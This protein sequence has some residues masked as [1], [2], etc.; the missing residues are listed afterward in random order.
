MA[1][2]RRRVRLLIAVLAL[3]FA[4]VVAR[5]LRP[6]VPVSPH[7]PS[8]RTDP[9]AVAEVT[10]GRLERIT[11]SRQDVSVDFQR[12]LL[13]PDGSMKLFAVKI[14]T[15]ERGGTRTFT[16]TG[17]EG[18]VGEKE[19]VLTLDGDVQ[20]VAS[21]GLTVRTEHATY[22]GRDGFVRAPGPVQFSRGRTKGSGLGMTYD[23]NRDVLDVLHD[24][25]LSIAPDSNGAGA[26]EITSAA[27]EFARR[28]RY[29]R[30]DN[31]V[32]IVRG[33][34][35][36][37]A[38]NATAYLTED[39]ERIDTLD[40]RDNARITV[41]GAAVGGLQSLAGG[42]MNLKYGSD[43][44]S[45]QHALIVG[46]AVVQIAGDAGKAG[47][48]I[49][50]GTL[51]IGLAPDGSTPIALAARENVQLT[52][53]AE[54]GTVGRTIQ[55]ANL[56]AKGVAERGL[57][58]AHF[59]GSVR[60]LEA[61]QG[62]SRAARSETLDAALKP[63]M[64]GLEDA[65]FVRGVHFEEGKLVATSATA[66]YQPD[67]GTLQLSG[68]EAGAV[69]PRVVNDQIAVDAAQID[70]TLDGPKVKATGSPADK[71]K[72]VLQPA[73][74]EDA[75]PGATPVKMPSMLK[76]D[77]PVNVTAATLDYDGTISKTAYSGSAQL[78]Q[79]DTSIKGETLVID[80]KAGDLSATAVTTTTLLEQ[81]NNETKKKERVRSTATAKDLKYEDAVRRMT[82]TGDA[83]M[84]GPEGD[85]TAATIELYLKPSGDELER[86]EAY[87]AVTL[88]EQHRKTTGTRMTYTT[89][90]ERYVIV[91][92]PVKIVDQCE[93]ETTGRTLT[94]LKASD[95]VVVDGNQETRTETKGGGKC[96]S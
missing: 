40:L 94:F 87:E 6:R 93:R 71:V 10:D 35:T 36:I 83:H 3:A 31:G 38:G 28:D 92:A 37:E 72:S 76:Q 88:R 58:S 80:G 78:W 43:G 54:A 13:Y 84:I 1:L 39:G 32:R 41:P 79:G 85:M 91:G 51:D 49:S 44:Q 5:Q 81:T 23:K 52:I 20:V 96:P 27:V 57:T 64:S 73:H 77:Q 47:R 4:A 89:A 45:L 50:A 8:T 29:T 42:T 26:T 75:A 95:N 63:G 7:L 15:D 19:S 46:T 62:A 90:D 2:W 11:F 9:A 56:D 67:K 86:A 25:V 69:V 59:Y 34:E 55:S 74:N 82:Y 65:R 30:F 68:S 18:H 16:V 53:P 22:D 60:F 24:A 33:G 14:K 66:R 61:G 21:D 48:Q 70:V 17:N 12:Q